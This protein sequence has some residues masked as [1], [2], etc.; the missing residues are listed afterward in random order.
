MVLGERHVAVVGVLAEAVM[1]LWW[2]VGW[3]VRLLLLLLLLL[4]V[5]SW[6]GWYLIVL[7]VWCRCFGGLV[8]VS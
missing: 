1:Q 6:D 7:K 2:E 4:Y 5:I 3:W 8:C